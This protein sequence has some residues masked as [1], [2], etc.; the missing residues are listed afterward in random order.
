ME[1]ISRLRHLL[2][3]L[4][5]KRYYLEKQ[6]EQIPRMLP[7]CLILRYRATGTRDF[8]TVKREGKLPEGKSYAY[9]T[10]LEK[11]VTR[12]RYIAKKDIE[13]IAKLTEPYKIFCEKMAEVRS[14]NR[15]ITELLDKIGEM[16]QEDV[17]DY[18]EKRVK[19]IRVK[20]R[21]K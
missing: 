13:R 17:K 9:L 15:R 18:V 16:Q 3:K 5:Q 6:I 14:L 11:E 10:Y 12:H 4:R 8:Q 21:T 2:S 1:S 19:R 7:A 20:K